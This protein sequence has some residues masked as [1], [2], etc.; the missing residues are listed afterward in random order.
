MNLQ[1][2]ISTW[3]EKKGN[4]AQVE[5]CHTTKIVKSSI[6]LTHSADAEHST[7]TM[8]I[9][10]TREFLS[11]YW[12][13]ASHPFSANQMCMLL[14]LSTYSECNNVWHVEVMGGVD[15]WQI[16]GTK[17]NFVES[18]CFWLSKGHRHCQNQ[19]HLGST[20][21]LGVVTLQH[22]WRIHLGCTMLPTMC[23]QF[24][25]LNTYLSSLWMMSFEGQSPYAMSHLF[26]LEHLHQCSVCDS[27]Q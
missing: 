6:S 22:D 8:F 23:F 26:T 15:Q 13:L 27:R 11:E 14:S 5:F 4:N 21:A 18:S 16:Q 17:C 2:L 1:I 20:N 24:S 10:S 9:H 3:S 7:C 19:L 25:M 12:C